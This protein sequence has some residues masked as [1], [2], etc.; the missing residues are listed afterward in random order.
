LPQFVNEQK[1]IT[2]PTRLDSVEKGANE[3]ESF[4]RTA[5]FDADQIQA[6][7]TSVREALANAI[8]HG[9]RMDETKSVEISLSSLPAGLEITI[10]DFGA[11]FD[12]DAIADPT[13]PENLL[14]ESG[15]G[16]LFMR[17]FMDEVG[18]RPHPQGGTVLRI[19]KSRA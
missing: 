1:H 11:G 14:K 16:I 8:K 18:W 9:N 10:R 13:K 6:I 5:G 2:L 7:D 12:P 15:R 4:A 17:A 19:L 3:V